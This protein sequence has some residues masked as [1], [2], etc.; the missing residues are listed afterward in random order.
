MSDAIKSIVDGYVGLK[1]R[2]TLEEMR[3]HRQRLRRSLQERA[4]V[5]S[6]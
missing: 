4:G 3:D 6:I 1:D 2:V 5:L